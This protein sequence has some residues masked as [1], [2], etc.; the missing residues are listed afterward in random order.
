MTALCWFRSD[1]RIQDNP[2]LS[3]ALQNGPAYALFIVSPLQWSRHENADSKV[4]F[5]WRALNALQPELESIGVTLKL[6]RV[7]RWSDVPQALVTFCQAHQIDAV[8]CNREHG[9]HERQRDRASYKALAQVG[10]NM[11]GYDGQT[12][13]APGTVKTGNDDYYRVFTPFSKACKIKI[14]AL[15]RSQSPSQPQSHPDPY[16][17]PLLTLEHLPRVQAASKLGLVSDDLHLIWPESEAAGR[18]SLKA[19]QYLTRL[20]PADAASVAQRLD[21]FTQSAIKQYKLKRDLPSEP[22]TSMMSPYLA[23]GLV[24]AKTCLNKAL[25]ANHGEIDKGNEGILSWIN[26][27]LWREFYQHLLHGYPKLSKH[28][29]LREDTQG[30]PWRQA[31]DDFKAW[32]TGQTGIPIVDAAMRQLLHMGWMHNRL[33]MIV[34][35]FLTKNLLIDWRQ[36]ESFFMRHLID[37]DLAANNGG[38]QWSASTG[39]DA[40]PYFRVFNPVSQSEKFDAQGTFIRQWVPELKSLDHKSIHDPTPMQ[41]QAL[42]YPLPIVDLKSSR[43][44]AIEAFKTHLSSSD[45]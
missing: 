40:A 5:W 1:L 2:A 13:L 12:L 3:A 27:I 44:R 43:A 7:E 19:Q 28:Q 37:G 14:Q 8:H 31:P 26:E 34:A 10:V 24:S 30:I 23:A 15:R 25:A 32:S 35:M 36:G 21:A 45:H 11:L 6:L 29:P 41:R 39:A 4:H 20:W 33:R 9:D 17:Y 22:G 18:L 16:P 42:G 38:W